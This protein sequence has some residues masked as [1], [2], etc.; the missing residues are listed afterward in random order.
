MPL[1]RNRK[2]F[3]FLSE[4]QISIAVFVSVGNI[5]SVMLFGFWGIVAVAVMAIMAQSIL[6]TRHAGS[7]PSVQIDWS[8]LRKLVAVG[9]PV[10]IFGCA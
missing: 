2:E 1:L 3:V 5:V 4:I 6:L 8:E 10:L 9:V 7:I